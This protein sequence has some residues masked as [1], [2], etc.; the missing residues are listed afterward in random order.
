[1][2]IHPGPTDF[3][4][5]ARRA[6]LAVMLALCAAAPVAAGDAPP[7]QEVSIYMFDGSRYRGT[8]QDG[9]PHGRGRIDWSKKRYYT[10]SFVHGVIE[11]QGKMTGRDDYGD[12]VYQGS[13]KRGVKHGKG[14]LTRGDGAFVFEGQFV[15]G[16]M[17]GAGKLTASGHAVYEGQ[18]KNDKPD[19]HGRMTDDDGTV[20]E[21]Q[22]Y[23]FDTTGVASIV[24]PSGERYQG[25]QMVG[26]PHGDGVLTRADQAVLRGEFTYGELKGD[27]TITYPDGAVYTGKVRDNRAHGPGE[28]RRPDGQI[29]RGRFAGD[30]PDGPG[31]LTLAG[32][33][34]QTGYWRAGKY[35]GQQ[36]GGVLEEGDNTLDD[37]PELA[38]SNNQAALYNQQALLQRQFD[39]LRPSAAAGPAQMYALLVA[40]DGTQE[41]FR[42]EV[43][44]VDSLLARRFG[45]RGQTVR[46]VNSRSS[47]QQL[48]LATAHSIDLALKALAQKMDRQRDL[49][50]VFLTG[51]GSREH[52]LSI[53][54]N[55]MALPDL[56][57]GQLRALLDASGIR[58]KV[59]VV[60]ACYSGGFIP[61]LQGDRTWVITAASAD[62]TSFGCADDNDF[63]YFG[64]ALFKESLTSAPTLSAAFAHA[65]AQVRQWEQRDASQ[66]RLAAVKTRKPARNSQP[67]SGADSSGSADGEAGNDNGS[68]PQ[69]VATP[70]FQTEVDAWFAT[71]P[72][73]ADGL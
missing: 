60:S 63:T 32:G 13:F 29:Y 26:R 57:A 67:G 2:N 62:R 7:G 52:E 45:T 64:R 47:V 61:A 59:V 10:G 20:I 8:M 15:N 70:A 23:G 31:Q 35:I 38:A 30:Q 73:L 17:Q 24:W 25:P 43:A 58:N 40:G 6:L 22:F 3:F 44:Y 51:H 41:V 12:Y 55:G 49:L 9:K 5:L 28:L 16:H 14:K 50:F 53:G 18:F 37:T 21:G 69:S 72:P 33:T 39:Q 36:G 4:A 19:G 66:R 54:M 56:N 1:M 34:L 68:Q 27:A 71:H 48:P 11:G 65:D 46:L 42:R